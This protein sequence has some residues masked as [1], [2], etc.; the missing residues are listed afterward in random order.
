M[1]TIEE[2][3]LLY[4]QYRDRVS[5]VDLKKAL[6]K[7]KIETRENLRIELTEKYGANFQQ[8]ISMEI[9]KLEELLSGT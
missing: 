5:V 9:Q 8:A 3:Q 7:Q 6:L 1:K 2:V 4:K